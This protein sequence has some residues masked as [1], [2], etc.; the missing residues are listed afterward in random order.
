MGSKTIK[1]LK[2]SYKGYKTYSY[3]YGMKTILIIVILFISFLTQAQGFE[4]GSWKEYLPYRNVL[5][6][7]HLDNKYYAATPYSLYYLDEDDNS[8]ERLTEIN[9]LSDFSI[10]IMGVN[11]QEKAIVVGYESGNIDLIK[12]GEI[13][14]LSGIVSSNIIGDKR[15]YNVYSSGNL[16]YLACGFGIVVIDIEK[17]EVKD[18]YII[19]V[20]GSQV[21]INDITINTDTIYAATDAGVYKAGLSSVFLSDPT[22]WSI[23]NNI[24]P[25]SYSFIT[26]FGG[27]LLLNAKYTGFLTDTL[28]QL[29]NGVFGKVSSLSNNDY[30]DIQPKDNNLLLSTQRGVLELDEN[31]QQVELLYTYAETSFVNPNSC[32]WNDGAYWVA[33]K[34]NGMVKVINNFNFE[35]YLLQGPFSNDVFHLATNNNDLWV[36]S[37]RTEGSAWNSTFNMNGIYHY[38][39]EDWEMY[40]GLTNVELSEVD[41][42]FDFVHIAIDPLDETHIMAS[43]FKGGVVEIKDGKYVTRHT[44]YNS[45]LQRRLTDLTK[46]CASGSAFDEDGNFWVANA[47]VNEPL[48]L[49]TID[50]TWKSFVCSAEMKGGIVTELYIDKTNGYLW[51]GA[52]GGGVMVYDFNKTP[53][54]ETDDQFKTLTTVEG[55]GALPSDITNTIVEDKN[56]AIWLGTENGPVV[57]YYPRN[58]FEG[59][60]YYAQEILIEQDGILEVLLGSEDI[61]EIVVDGANRKWFATEGG[62]LFLISADGTEMINSFTTE[63]SPIFS[64]TINALA[65]NPKT[66][67]VYVGTDKGIMGFKGEATEPNATFNEVY[68]Y[69]NPVR[70]EYQGKIA[71]KGLTNSAD[72]KITDASGNLV[73]STTSL[74]GQAVWDGKTLSGERVATGVYYVFLVTEDGSDKIATKLLFVN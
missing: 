4:L 31:L 30:F 39:S 36:S 14:N 3:F 19:G 35:S 27:R 41:S 22:N 48:S 51:M 50:G 71:I 23:E 26:S 2:N 40:N 7:V 53:E 1:I 44:W 16:T 11:E 65:I 45:S 54:D 15:V 28:Y 5:N 63:N 24:A 74:G 55:S 25:L 66:G 42:I 10:S 9:S 61:N 21:K 43:S 69:P 59:G 62:G 32:I 46:T 58:I 17:E 33:D 64:N 8:I 47:F 68:A 34:D 49:Y 73:A 18:T 56:G 20:G 70:P 6:I 38:N 72:V 67:E 52:K 37:G 12:N 57:I 13:I 60:N 29:E